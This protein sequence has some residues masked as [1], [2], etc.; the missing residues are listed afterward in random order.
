V[1]CSINNKVVASYDKSAL[2]TA[3]K[4]KTTDSVYGIRFAHNTEAIVPASR[5]QSVS[6]Y[7][8]KV[9]GKHL[10]SG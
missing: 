6:L 4:F 1:E 3:G 8:L 10:V 9:V 7:L 5:S 2:V